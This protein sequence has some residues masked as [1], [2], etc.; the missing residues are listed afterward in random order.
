MLQL[1]HARHTCVPSARSNATLAGATCLDAELTE[2]GAPAGCRWLLLSL[3]TGTGVAM[4]GS[5]LVVVVALPLY[6]LP[7]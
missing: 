4:A 6:T 2:P 5:E 7:P 1:K 3:L